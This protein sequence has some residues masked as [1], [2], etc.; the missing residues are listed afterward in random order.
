[1]PYDDETLCDRILVLLVLDFYEYQ[2]ST[3]NTTFPYHFSTII[4]EL[5]LWGLVADDQGIKCY[6]MG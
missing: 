1:M 4:M 5:F 2:N 3:K 6:K